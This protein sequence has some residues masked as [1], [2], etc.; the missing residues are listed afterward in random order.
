MIGSINFEVDSCL[1]INYATN[2]EGEGE[3]SSDILLC[4]TEETTDY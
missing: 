4:K 1:V 2:T 3:I